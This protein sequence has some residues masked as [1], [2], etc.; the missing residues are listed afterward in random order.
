MFD[1]ANFGTL[2]TIGEK[3]TGPPPSRRPFTAATVKFNPQTAGDVVATTS[4][5][6]RQL[7]RTDV[8]K[9]QATCPTLIL[10]SQQQDFTCDHILVSRHEL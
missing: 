9:F 5:R 3:V 10:T 7:G 8:S 2:A 6:V 4:Q 1:W